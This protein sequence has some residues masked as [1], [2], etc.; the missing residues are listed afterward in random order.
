MR[1]YL[2]RASEDVIAQFEYAAAERTRALA[3][4]TNTRVIDVAAQL[5]GRRERFVDLVHFSNEG[6]D[7]VA[8][9]I[10]EEMKG[11]K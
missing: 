10:V 3:K 11:G 8:S 9:L 6:N 7:E 5:S 1:V 2:P 4:E